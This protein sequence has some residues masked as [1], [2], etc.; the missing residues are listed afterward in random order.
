VSAVLS[1]G[2]GGSD[3]AHSTMLFATIPGAPPAD[4]AQKR[5][6]MRMLC[7]VETDP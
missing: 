2:F 3:P 4:P 5:V 1:E 7:G 6:P